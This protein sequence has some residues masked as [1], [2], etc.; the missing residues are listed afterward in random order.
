MGSRASSHRE[1]SSDSESACRPLPENERIA[2]TNVSTAQPLPP[3]TAAFAASDGACQRIRWRSSRAV[4]R[5]EHLVLLARGAQHLCAH[6][7][8]ELCDAL[9]VRHRR[10]G[11]DAAFV[12]RRL[13]RGRLRRAWPTPAQNRRREAVDRDAA[14]RVP[15]ESFGALSVRAKLRLGHAIEPERERLRERGGRDEAVGIAI[16]ACEH[17]PHFSR[18]L[19]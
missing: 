11:I 19:R 5:R 1:R 7:L 10:S 2:A 6:A 12:L 3:Y 8:D 16:E 14:W 15:A 13:L 9:F 18:T 4:R 17:A